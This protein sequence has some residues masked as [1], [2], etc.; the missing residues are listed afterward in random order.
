MHCTST[1]RAL[2]Q[3]SKAPQNSFCAV[4]FERKYCYYRPFISLGGIMNRRIFIIMVGLLALLGT[5][6]SSD[7][8]PGDGVGSVTE[9]DGSGDTAGDAG[10]TSDD[11]GTGTPA[12]PCE[13]DNGGC[14]EASLWTCSVDA[15]GDLQC[16][17][18]DECQVNNG[19]CPDP[20]FW[21]CINNKGAPP[22]CKDR[23][24]CATDNG[25]CGDPAVWHCT[26]FEG[27]APH[28]EF[29]CGPDWTTL[30][31]D[32]A[33]LELGGSLP[34]DHVIHGAT[35]CPL[36]LIQ[37]NCAIAAFA[38][39]E[40]GR[41]MQMGHESQ[42][43]GGL[44]G[45]GDA[46]QLLLNTIAWMAQGKELALVGVD[47]DLKGASTFL[48][49]KGV[50]NKVIGLDELETVDIYIRNVYANLSDAQNSLIQTWV[51]QGGGLIT[52]GHCWYWSSSNENCPVNHPGNKMLWGSGITISPATTE[53]GTQ[54]FGTEAPTPLHHAGK[55]LPLIKE[56]LLGGVELNL[57]E[58]TIT[59]QV[60]GYAVDALNLDF[61]SY[62][63]QI[64]P[65]LNEAPVIP[66]KQEPVVPAEAPVAFL[67]LKIANRYAVD[68]PP[69]ELTPHP[70]ASDF[71]GVPAA[72]A[73]SVTATVTIDGSY[74]GRSGKYFASNAGAARWSSTG[75]WAPPGQVVSIT[76]PSK[77]INALNVL[78]G[79]HTDKLWKK[80]KI[81]RFPNLVRSYKI[82]EETIQ[83]ANAFGGMI[84]LRTPGGTSLGKMEVT[85]EGAV[86]APFYV[87]GVTTKQEWLDTIR[88]YPAPFAEF[89]TPKIAFT[90]P[91]AAAAQIEDP[92]ALMEMWEE[93]MDSYSDLDGNSYTRARA[94]RFSLDR[95]ISAG[96]WHSGYPI[97]GHIPDS[98]GLL[99]L[100]KIKASGSWGPFHELGHNHQYKDWHLPG[101]TESTCNLWSVYVSEVYLGLDLGSSHPAINLEK[102]K[103]R[104]A[105]Y[106]ATGPDFSKWSVWTALETY[107][108]LEEA[109]GWGFYA[110]LFTEY[111]NL[112]AN[113]KP[114][115]NQERIDQWVIRSSKA[116]E[117]NL[118]PF[119]VSW[120]FPIDDAVINEVAALPEWAD[121]PML[122]FD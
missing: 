53:N 31:Q 77:A 105:S 55:A 68:L 18:I 67:M 79:S 38:R 80:D 34:S 121:N 83:V 120:G 17:D 47:N 116:V 59:A 23:D 122:N 5:A 25:G 44:L 61:E 8:E 74:A 106:L 35:V 89:V 117:F 63:D 93:I 43:N 97:M 75:L 69:E 94:E 119:Y 114:K 15:L 49:N 72:G 57:E 103:E 39:W 46:G 7:G 14:G 12:D 86:R 99:D 37:S 21:E 54:E 22:L 95:Q 36:L 111:R 2:T 20:E 90:V 28:Y 81:Q 100:N 62:Y 71:P 32:V 110:P 29:D 4:R 26:N 9:G 96:G 101:T 10:A 70:A 30:T 27:T 40:D 98:G 60:V 65:L 91:S 113:E 48:T 50:P 84:Y 52:G 45:N 108:Q 88:Y 76:V 82:T 42:I 3:K 6:C 41:V 85:I 51:K 104:L 24:E 33:K 118:G 56:H 78:V 11:G 102:R 66:T 16:A 112:N 13:T 115:N 58:Q 64:E 109:F 107:L 73:E 87:H 19:G 1:E 92:V